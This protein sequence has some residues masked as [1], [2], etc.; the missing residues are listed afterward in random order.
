MPMKTTVSDRVEQLYRG[1]KIRMSRHSEQC[2]YSAIGCCTCTIYDLPV[3]EDRPETHPLDGETSKGYREFS[4]GA[5][6]DTA[7]GKLDVSRYI[8]PLVLKRFAEYM[9]EKQTM[10]DGTTRSGDNWQKGIPPQELM[11][12]LARHNLDIWL[13]MKEEGGESTEGLDA[14]LMGALFNTMALV[15]HLERGTL[16]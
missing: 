12:S 13:H 2:A 6:R 1:E 14:A 8:H 10:P 16:K 4:T 3:M 5:S 11:S 9:L 15:L 7:I